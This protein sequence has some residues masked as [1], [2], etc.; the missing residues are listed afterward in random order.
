MWVFAWLI[1]Q[2]LL[3]SISYNLNDTSFKIIIFNIGVNLRFT[4]SVNYPSFSNDL[5]NLVCKAKISDNRSLLV[6]LEVPRLNLSE[7]YKKLVNAF[8]VAAKSTCVFQ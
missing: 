3:K 5:S 7:A 1:F 8:N 2:M 4:D 6:H